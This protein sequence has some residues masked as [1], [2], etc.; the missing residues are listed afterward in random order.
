MTSTTFEHES[1]ITYAQTVK[2]EA[3]IHQKYTMGF[4]SLTN[5]YINWWDN[6]VYYAKMFNII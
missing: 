4:V 3:Y 2:L 6:Y 1:N 5:S